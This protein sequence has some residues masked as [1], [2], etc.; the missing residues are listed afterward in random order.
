MLAFGPL[1]T[2]LQQNKIHWYCKKD[3]TLFSTIF[4]L[5]SLLMSREGSFVVSKRTI[6]DCVVD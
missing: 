3:S 1:A 2:P 4:N 5:V 6:I